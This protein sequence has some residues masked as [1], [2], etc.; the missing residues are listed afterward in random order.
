[1]SSRLSAWR[2]P[3]VPRAADSV[4]CPAQGTVSWSQDASAHTHRVPGI[5]SMTVSP[6][7]SRRG[8]RRLKISHRLQ[9][10]A[11]HRGL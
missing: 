10:Q 9:L 3:R 6:V 2:Y 11:V 1:M 4:M 7:S 5:A 8:A